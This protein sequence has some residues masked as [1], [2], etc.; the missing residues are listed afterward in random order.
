[1]LEDQV[2]GEIRMFSGTYAPVG[3]AL[4]HGQLLTISENEILFTLIGTTYGG[5]GITT[6]ALPDLRGRIPI[7]IGNNP[8][9]SDFILGQ[10][11]GTER[12]V[13]NV[14]QLPY[15]T[16]TVFASTNDAS[17][18]YP[19]NAI[20]AKSTSQNYKENPQSPF[21]DMNSSA[22]DKN[23]GNQAHNNMMPFQCINFIIALEGIYPSFN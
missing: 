21:S 1:M 13:L 3:W 2:V 9:G 17:T 20:W 7:G 4:C 6:F 19:Q 10:K 15:H 5:D 18:V 8:S 23:G 16:H 14:N 12:E 11:G 22:I